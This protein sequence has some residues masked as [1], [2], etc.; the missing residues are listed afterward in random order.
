MAHY[1]LQAF[2]KGKRGAVHRVKTLTIDETDPHAMAVQYWRLLRSPGCKDLTLRVLD[3]SAG[4]GGLAP[5]VSYE[6]L[7]RR[8]GSKLAA[9]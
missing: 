2:S 1:Q 4:R 3:L 7:V 6:E 5:V 8:A 9:P